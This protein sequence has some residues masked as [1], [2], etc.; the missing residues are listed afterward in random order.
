[1]FSPQSVTDPRESHRSDRL[2]VRRGSP[3]SFFPVPA[4]PTM[5][6]RLGCGQGYGDPS[7]RVLVRSGRGSSV[8]NLMH[9]SEGQRTV[10]AAQRG[11]LDR[12][13]PAGLTG[14]RTT[15]RSLTCA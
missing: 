13:Y 8:K 9:F 15:I 3:A 7:I 4:R 12:V 1:M 14:T 2:Q 5:T 10:A 6:T 11:A